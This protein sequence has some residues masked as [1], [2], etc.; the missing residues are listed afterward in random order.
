MEYVRNR[1]H[2][3]YIKEKYNQLVEI[4]FQV[5]YKYMWGQTKTPQKNVD[6]EKLKGC[7]E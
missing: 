1:K 5:M 4:F 7:V 6:D 3:K 2:I